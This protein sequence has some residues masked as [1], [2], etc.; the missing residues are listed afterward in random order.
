M[1]TFSP[2]LHF[3]YTQEGGTL[4]GYSLIYTQ[5]GGTLVGYS[6]MV[7]GRKAGYTP[8]YY[9]PGTPWWVYTSLPPYPVHHPGYTTPSHHP[10]SARLLTMGA[11]SS[12]VTR[13][14]ALP[15]V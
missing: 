4:V 3:V 14:W 1:P 13:L 9:L 11:G 12:G 8:P 2:V 15:W 5:E 7:P 6:H 10:V